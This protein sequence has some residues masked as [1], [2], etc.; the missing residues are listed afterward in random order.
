MIVHFIATGPEWVDSIFSFKICF[1]KN[2]L[3]VKN[4]YIFFASQKQ[5]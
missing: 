5:T 4:I 2:K 3:Y 1:L